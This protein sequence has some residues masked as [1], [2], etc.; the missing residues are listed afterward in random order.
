MTKNML[1]YKYLWKYDLTIKYSQI[2]IY[3][4]DKNSVIMFRKAKIVLKLTWAWK[5]WS[6]K[7]YDMS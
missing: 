2:C 7:K 5:N 3:K 1:L 4:T 6:N